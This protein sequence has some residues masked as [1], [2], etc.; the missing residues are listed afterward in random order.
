MSN[1]TQSYIQKALVH[2]YLKGDEYIVLFE[3]NPNLTQHVLS[4]TPPPLTRES[5]ESFHPGGVQIAETSS[6][7]TMYD[8]PIIL[9]L[10]QMEL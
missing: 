4:V 3:K 6:L 7:K 10:M 2:R 1:F 8:I 9:N 5:V